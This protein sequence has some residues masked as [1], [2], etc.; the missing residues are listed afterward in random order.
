MCYY[1]KS[2]ENNNKKQA[3]SKLDSVEFQKIERLSYI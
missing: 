1:I 2:A 3:Q